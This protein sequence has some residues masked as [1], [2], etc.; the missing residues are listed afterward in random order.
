MMRAAQARGHTVFGASRPASLVK[1]TVGAKATRISLADND[2][3]WYRPHEK[4]ERPLREFDAVLMR[5][6][7]PFDMEYV[8]SSWLLS[9]AERDG[10]RVFNAP[11]ALR[12]HNEKL[13]IAEF[14]DFTVPSLVARAMED[15]QAFIEEHRNVVL[16]HLDGMAPRHLP[17]HHDT[18]THV[19]VTPLRVGT[20]A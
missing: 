1:S 16:K 19:S 15:L 3:D 10:T 6:D 2:E 8:A 7:P 11:R 18:P 12:D 14:P 4:A 20:R 9:E 5:K 17:V 13:A